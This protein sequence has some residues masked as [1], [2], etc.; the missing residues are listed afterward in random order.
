[1]WKYE[2]DDTRPV[3]T[4]QANARSAHAAGGEIHLPETAVLFFMSGGIEYL[5]KRHDC[6]MITQS[7]PRFLQKCP[8]YEWG[9]ACFLHGGRG[10]PQAADTL[11]TLCA[12]GVKRVLTVGLCGAFAPEL[13]AGDIIVPDMALVEEG[14]SLH[15]YSDIDRAYPDKELASRLASALGAKRAGVVS[16]DAVYRQTLY[17]ERLWRERGAACVEMETSAIFS[18]SAY[19]GMSAAT[20]LAVSDV[21]T[22]CDASP[23]WRWHMTSDMRL[24]VLENIVDKAFK[25]LEGEAD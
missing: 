2:C 16:C 25:M 15:Y 9:G 3:I 12:L 7:L 18:V 22:V 8:V 20:A 10:A 17:K 6:R 14:T 23:G 24:N 21:H 4:A 5:T 13:N 1:M 19:L 11:E